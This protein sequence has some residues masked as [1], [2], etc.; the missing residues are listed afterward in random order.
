M[1]FYSQYKQDIFV[2]ETFFKNKDTPGVF[3]EIGADDGVRF[4]NCKFFEETLKWTGLAIEA[5]DSAFI[6]LKKNRNCICENVVLSNIEEETQFMDIKGYGLGLSGLINKYDS[7]H[8]ERIDNEI[9]HVNNKGSDIINVK[10]VKLNDIL[11]KYNIKHIDFLS[12]DTEGSELDI[13]STLD[14]SKY[15]ID[16]ITIEDNYK[17]IKLLNFFQERNYTLI[18]NIGCDK[19]FKRNVQ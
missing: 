14:F 13:L 11:D 18:Q 1:N 15:I 2:Y 3:L 9:K 4:S 10:T 8:V 17:D 7:R 5:R 12:I 6:E 19:I 16:I